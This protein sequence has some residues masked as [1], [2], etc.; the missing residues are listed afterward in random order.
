MGSLFQK[1]TRT[2]SEYIQNI[3]KEGE[4]EKELTLRK[5]GNSGIGLS[6]ANIIL[7]P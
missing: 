6:K 3:Y 2:I 4:L 5:S 7:Q 1:D